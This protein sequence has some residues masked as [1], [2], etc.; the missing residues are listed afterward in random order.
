MKVCNKTI[1]PSQHHTLMI[2]SLL[3]RLINLENGGMHFV[4]AKSGYYPEIT[5]SRLLIKKIEEEDT[6]RLLKYCQLKVNTERGPIVSMFCY[7]RKVVIF[8][9]TT[10]K[11]EI[12]LPDC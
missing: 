1:I 9:D 5:K 12:S 6:V 7:V 8:L 11:S 2:S 3:H 4:G 10:T